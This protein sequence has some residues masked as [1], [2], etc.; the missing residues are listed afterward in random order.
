MST[1][2]KCTYCGQVLP[3]EKF[4]KNKFG[5]AGHMAQCADCENMLERERRLIKRNRDMMAGYHS[6]SMDSTIE[7]AGKSGLSYGQLVARRR[8]QN[9]LKERREQ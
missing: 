2:R 1:T 9:E 5:W 7:E 6:A 4:H 3:L 8:W